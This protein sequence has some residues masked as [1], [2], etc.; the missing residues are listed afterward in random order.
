VVDHCHITGQ[1]RGLLCSECNL[2]L[3]KAKDNITTLQN[4][5]DYLS[6]YSQASQREA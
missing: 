3:G 1:V 6:E 2:M 4:A 5:I